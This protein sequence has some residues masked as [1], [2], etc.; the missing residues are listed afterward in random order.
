MVGPIGLFQPFRDAI[1]LFCK[2]EEFLRYTQ[3]FYWSF[4]PILSLILYLFILLGYPLGAGE[5]FF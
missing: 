2:R 1:K 5:F 4:A 3:K